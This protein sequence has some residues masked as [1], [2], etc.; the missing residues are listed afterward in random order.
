MILQHLFRPVPQLLPTPGRI[1]GYY[2]QNP[3]IA[4]SQINAQ[5][6]SRTLRKHT[7]ALLARPTR[8]STA[9]LEN[10]AL[11]CGQVI[12]TLACLE[13]DNLLSKLH[14]LRAKIAMHGLRDDYCVEVTAI[15]ST[16][17][18]RTLNKTPY[19]VQLMAVRAMLDDALAQMQ[20][21]EGKTLAV[22]LSA[23]IAA[24]A[25]V[26]VL[27]VTANDYLVT[28]DQA[29]MQA[30]FQALGIGSACVTRES[31]PE[32]R[33]QAYRQAIC[34]C[35]AKELAFDYL[36]DQTRPGDASD[37]AFGET[38]QTSSGPLLRGLCMAIIDEADSILLDEAVTPLILSRAVKDEAQLLRLKQAHMIA[39]KLWPKTHFDV[40]GSE[41]RCTL[42]ALGQALVGAL[43]ADHQLTSD[44]VWQHQRMREELVGLALNAMHVYQKDRDYVVRAG[45]LKMIDQPTGRVA[46]GR[47]WSRGLHQLLELKESLEPSAQT[48]TIA[49][50]NFQ[51]LFPRFLRFAG[52]SGSLVEAATELRSIYQR[53][54]VVIPLNRPSLR[55]ST[56]PILFAN[57]KLK[58]VAVLKLVRELHAL[59]RPILLGTDS[60]A[61]SRA[62][63]RQLS[64]AG[65]EHHTLTAAQDLQEAEIISM[66]GQRNAITI[67]TNLAGRGTDIHIDESVERL[68]GLAVISCHLNPERRIDRQ[69]VGRSARQGQHGSSHT[70]VS[71]DDPLFIRTL[72]TGLDRIL[73]RRLKE[74]G[75]AAWP[76]LVRY[77]QWREESRAS[78]QRLNLLE[79]QLIKDRMLAM[80]GKGE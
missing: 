74:Q 45:E 18:T 15:V 17:S 29:L 4:P 66:A 26:P 35:T 38:Q 13:Q 21:G 44:S 54:T 19:P 41:R 53:R 24:L 8:Q 63:A 49:Q 7:A 65:L 42:N 33:R 76:F 14:T 71:L 75:Q 2:P 51:S 12:E 56:Q 22:G 27:I 32:A 40:L 72:P 67:T 61:A 3:S 6:W 62:L 30:L 55:R 37:L 80:A 11:A 58:W 1:W 59:G 52:V 79:N 57:A 70:L 47:K 39:K 50:I 28:R 20:T 43:C 25:G 31:T 5:R 64:N 77:A 10:F 16:F 68:G 23:A 73:R 48:E 69:L 78:A 34:Y 9:R 60:V 46:E 36:R